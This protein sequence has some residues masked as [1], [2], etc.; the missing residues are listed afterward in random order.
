MLSRRPVAR[1]AAMGKPKSRR[2]R[3][4]FK[5]IVYQTAMISIILYRNIIRYI[6]LHVCFFVYESNDMLYFLSR[7]SNYRCGRFYCVFRTNMP[8]HT[9]LMFYLMHTRFHAYPYFIKYVTYLE[10][11]CAL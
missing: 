10:L 8:V 6:M 3:I 9:C 11:L 5:G 4:V 7:T 2:R 1:V